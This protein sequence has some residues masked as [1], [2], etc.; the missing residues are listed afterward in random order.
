MLETL[1]AGVIAPAVID[2]AKTAA[3]RLI[4][5]KAATVE[6]IIALRNSDIEKMKVQAEVSQVSEKS[7][8][9]VH[10]LKDSSRYLLTAASLAASVACLFVPNVNPEF[11]DLSWQ[12]TSL[13]LGF[14]FGDTIRKK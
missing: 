4:G 12:V 10:A 13:G 9:W 5:T 14:L 8:V 1:I 6:E 2:I 7:P 3:G 11:I